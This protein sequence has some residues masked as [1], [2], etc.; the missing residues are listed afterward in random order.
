MARKEHNIHY[1]YKTTCNITKRYYIGMHSTS[2]IDDG[3]LGSGL[4]LRR[5]IRKYGKD[6]HTKEI[7]E[8]VETRELLAKREREIV[9][10]QLLSEDLCMN[11]TIGG[12]C[13]GYMNEEHMMKCVKAAAKSTNQKRWVDDRERNIK[14][15][16]ERMKIRL[17]DSKIKEK[18]LS[19]I[20]G[21]WEGKNLPNKT[22]Q[23][24]SETRKKYEIGKGNTNSQYGTC[25]I[26]NEIESKKIN[27]HDEVPNGWR[28]GRKM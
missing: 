25:W 24:I 14:E 19:G 16:S 12:E 26:T 3:Y 2:N 13:G 6:N 9:N 23:K 22:K 8:F 7:L 17:A 10:K 28:L 21:Y 11:L 18:Q 20:T 1:V 27:K 4:R 15:L 5:S